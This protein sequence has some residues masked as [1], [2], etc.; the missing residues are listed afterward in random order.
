[1][2]PEIELDGDGFNFAVP[3]GDGPAMLTGGSP[4]WE[5]INRPGRIALTK[6]TG[7][8][9]IKLDVPVFLDGWP[10]RS[11]E[12]EIEQILRLCRGRKGNRPPDFTASGPIPY[13]G[14]RFVMELPDWGDGVRASKFH[15]IHGELVRQELTLKLVQFI[16][17]AAIH[18]APRGRFGDTAVGHGQPVETTVLHDGETLLEVSKRI[19]GTAGRAGAIGKRNGIKDTR[20][21]LRAGKHLSL[22]RAE[23]TKSKSKGD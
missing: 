5:E 12:N 19:Y 8:T 11:V 16:T 23:P 21:G 17:S 22:P 13:S 3:L 20:R 15:G 4:T 14:A 6:Y 7:Q 9:L 1:M 18:F 2:K 10:D